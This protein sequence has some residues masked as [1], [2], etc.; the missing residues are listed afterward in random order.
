MA[1]NIPQD[2]NY[3]NKVKESF[4]KQT[5]MT[6]LNASLKE[7]SPGKVIIEIPYSKEFTQ[8]NGFIHAGVITSIVDT[9]CGYAAFSLFPPDFDVL[10]IEFK[11]NFLSPAIGTK[12]QAHGKVNKSGRTISVT[13]GEV[14]AITD[15]EE[16]LI[17]TM[18]ATMMAISTNHQQQKS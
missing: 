10:T 17:A 9:A 16:K 1:K 18:L 13:N 8:Q 15:K 4:E 14:Y 5:L 6:T 3:Q 7:V 12:F 2:A 11:I